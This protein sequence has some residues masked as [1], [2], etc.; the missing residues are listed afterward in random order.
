MLAG[1]VFI[2]V[3]TFSGIPIGFAADTYNRKILL[4]L[5]KSLVFRPH[6]FHNPRRPN[7]K[8]ST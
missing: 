6:K 5:G 1:P 3:F 8:L 4:G 2:V 7:P